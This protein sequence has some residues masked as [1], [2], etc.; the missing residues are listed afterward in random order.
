MITFPE[1]KKMFLKFFLFGVRVIHFIDIPIRTVLLVIF[2]ASLSFTFWNL[3]DKNISD[4]MLL[5]RRKPVQSLNSTVPFNILNAS[6]SLSLPSNEAPLT[7]P[8]ISILKL[9]DTKVL[10][11]SFIVYDN[12]ENKVIAQRNENLK[13]PPASL[14]KLLSVAVFTKDLNLDTYVKVPSECTFVNGQK[15]GFKASEKVSIKD[16]LYTSLIFSAAD[17]VCTLSKINPNLN[18][19]YFNSYAKTIGMNNSN[20]TNYIGLDYEDN[21]TTAFDILSLTKEFIKNDLFNQIVKQKSYKLENGKVVYNTNKMLF[22]NEYSVGIKTG[23]TGEANEN[24]IYRYKNESKKLD[25]IVIILNS[26]DRYQDTRN[27][28]SNIYLATE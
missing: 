10:A 11:K 14:V 4:L 18:L 12:S 3:K 1:S 17:S 26:S 28:I 6:S 5:T 16:L 13:L 22:E 23:T 19:D 2:T 20:F 15:L 25:L 24:L 9:K 27:I 7:K 21:E 8:P